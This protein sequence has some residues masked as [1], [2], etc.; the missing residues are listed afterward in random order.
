LYE[1]FETTLGNYIEIK[2]YNNYQM[3]E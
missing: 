3:N 2:V 1:N